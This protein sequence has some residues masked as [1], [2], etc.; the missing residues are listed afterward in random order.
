MRGDQLARQWRVIRAI[1]ASTNGLT[2]AEIANHNREETGITT[3]YRDLEA[4]QSAGFPLYTEKV[5]KANRWAFVDTYKFKIPPPFT[6][7]ELMSFYFYKDLVRVFKGTPLHDS[8]D[9]VFKK[10]QP[11][12][13]PKLCATWIRCSRFFMWGLTPTRIMLNSEIS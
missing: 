9:S 13:R 5:D 10:I 7:T 3:I 11:P 8:I 2:V 6:L 4:L 12:C 1:E